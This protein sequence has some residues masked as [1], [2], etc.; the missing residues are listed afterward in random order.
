MGLKWELATAIRNFETR[1]RDSFRKVSAR[2]VLCKFCQSLDNYILPL[3]YYLFFLHARFSLFKK[4]T[5]RTTVR[6]T[7]VI[8]TR[9]EVNLISLHAGSTAAVEVERKSIETQH[10][11]TNERLWKWNGNPKKPTKP[12]LIQKHF[13]QF[14]S[15]SFAQTSSAFHREH[16]SQITLQSVIDHKTR[17]KWSFLLLDKEMKKGK[18]Y[19]F[20]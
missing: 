4:Y 11:P 2:K 19:L 3:H 12:V 16:L 17:I 10:D 7:H 8:A 20:M 6:E 9:V 5:T 1:F 13:F 18:I 14:L 15:I